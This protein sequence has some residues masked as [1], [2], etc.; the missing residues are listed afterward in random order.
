MSYKPRTLFRLIEEINVSLFLPHIQRAFVW[1]REQMSRLLDSLMRN[2][3]IQTLLFWRTKDYIKAR[4]F[5]PSVEWDADLSDY[6]DNSKTEKGIEK[7]FVLDGQQRLQ[8]LYALFNG[9][10]KS[11]DGKTDLDA[12]LDITGGDQPNT[13][14][15][16]YRTVFSAKPPGLSFYRIRN[17]L[18]IDAQKN[19]LTLADEL[20]DEL[21]DGLKQERDAERKRQR[22]VR[23]NCSQLVSLLREEKHFWVEELDGVANQYPYK[24]ILDIFVRVN[25]GGTKLNAS[26]LMFAAMKEKW[27]AIEQ[28]IEEIVDLLN[29]GRL[30]F[31]KSFALKCLVVAHG[32]G[33]ELSAEQFSSPEG[34]TLVKTIEGE[35]HR[36]EAAFQEL[37]DF[38]TNDL[39]LYADKVI[40]SYSS[41]I[42]LFDYLYHNP[43]PNEA[44]RVLMRG[45]YYKSQ[46]FNWYGSQTDNVINAMHTRV[47]KELPDGFPLDTVKTYFSAS[48]TMPVE[49]KLTDLHNMQLRFI[50]LNLIY[51]ERFGASPF[52]VCFKGNEPHIDHIY[53]QS[54]LK[55]Q[56]KLTTPDI[57]HI[58][59]YRFVGATD[60]IR[61]RAEYPD[62]FFTRLKKQSV[63]V[64]SHLLVP[65]FAEDPALLK[66]DV[67]TYCDFRDRRLKAIFDIANKVVNPE[68]QK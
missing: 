6:Y 44:N 39:K 20:N 38:I 68:L 45:Y 59:N 53:P 57:N 4:R 10:V 63:D 1:D 56:L 23:E 48:R 54:A 25:S 49:L 52:N 51:V 7:V 35:W 36:A 26:D 37:R 67:P 30:D 8:S 58:G 64:V 66:F 11:N 29:G 46:L 60:N 55:S 43:K 5:M 65:A 27:S 24:K 15:L 17:L 31:D 21:D 47:G 12:Y 28:N 22:F 40:R 32:K 16:M 19:A 34:E 62:A 42:P 9:S 3:P 33:A 2:Y 13:E 61:K 18:G 41:F 14:G 50:I